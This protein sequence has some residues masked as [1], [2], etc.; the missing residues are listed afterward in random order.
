MAIRHR[1]INLRQFLATS[2]A[3]TALFVEPSAAFGEEPSAVFGK[4]PSAVL[5]KEPSA[6]LGKEP[7][8]AVSETANRVSERFSSNPFGSSKNLLEAP[9]ILPVEEVF[10]LTSSRAEG[11]VKLYW[12]ILPG[13]YLYRHRL[14]VTSEADLGNLSMMD[15]KPKFD[16][17]FGDVEVYYDE[18]EVVVPLNDESRDKVNLIV[19]YQGCAE[20]GLCY[21]PQKKRLSP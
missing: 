17:F 4:E 3:C 9:E 16:E 13:Y 11:V 21:P 10:R 6:A 14:K 19:E 1:K 8:A 20:A 18:L 7:S 5:N 12:Q 15:G 2:L